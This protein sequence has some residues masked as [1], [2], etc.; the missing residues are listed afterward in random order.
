MFKK[1]FKFFEGH[2]EPVMKI[3]G[4]EDAGIEGAV[5]HVLDVREAWLEVLIGHGTRVLEFT[6]DGV[7]EAVE[8]AIGDNFFKGTAAVVRFAVLL[9]REPTEEIFHAVVKRILDEMVA[10]TVVGFV[11][12]I[13]EDFSFAI[14]DLTHEDVAAFLGGPTLND[15]GNIASSYLFRTHSRTKFMG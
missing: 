8:V 3:V 6:E 13:D 5:A 10:D 2:R 1:G 12:S 4:G 11:I 14:E 9:A 15:R 7:I